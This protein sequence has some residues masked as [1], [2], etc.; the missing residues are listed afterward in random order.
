MVSVVI[1]FFNASAFLAEAIR[2]VVAQTYE[3][4][5]V[6]LVDDGSTDDS[7]LIAKSWVTAH[8]GRMR[9]LHHADHANRGI[10]A[11]RNL[12]ISHANGE[13]IAFLDA[14]DVWLP[15]KLDRQVGVLRAHPDV[16]MIY[17]RTQYW[18]SWAENV[19]GK[20]G[21]HTPSHGFPADTVVRPP[22]LLTAFL[23]DA[24]LVPCICSI[25]VRRSLLERLGGFEDSFQGLYEDQVFYAKVCLNASV[26][27][28]DDCL[29]RYRRHAG[30]LC[31]LSA[32]TG[33]EETWRRRYLRW[34]SR[35]VSEAAVVDRELSRA[36]RAQ[37]WIW[38]EDRTRHLPRWTR[39]LVRGAKKTLV[40]VTALV[41]RMMRRHSPV[42]RPA[43]TDAV[44][45]D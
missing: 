7:A 38:D 9:S 6:V 27:V 23:S 42:I 26:F 18:N 5:E 3:R 24:A 35:Y 39:R 15:N 29:E 41:P 21:D 2:S 34:L 10:S 22:S 28:S 30:S 17:G 13:L 16:G 44:T 37:L 12:G 32:H 40:N 14:D 4:W 20:S 36:L 25:L 31:M 19:D 43:R 33:A 8:P 11:S 45:P 1:P